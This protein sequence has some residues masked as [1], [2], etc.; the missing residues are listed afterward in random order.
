MGLSVCLCVRVGLLVCMCVWTF[1]KGNEG[2]SSLQ[3][4]SCPAVFS[5]ELVRQA[6]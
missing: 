4:I 3:W 6:V 1:G 5:L 2:G